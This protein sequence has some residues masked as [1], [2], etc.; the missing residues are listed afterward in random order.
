M[1]PRVAFRPLGSGRSF[2][3]GYTPSPLRG[4]CPC[5]YA[6]GRRVPGPRLS[7]ACSFGSATTMATQAWT[8]ASSVD[9]P[10]AT[11]A[12]GQLDDVSSAS[13]A[14]GSANDRVMVSTGS[15]SVN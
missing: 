3:R 8:M 14:D 7:L 15:S 1:S 13:L 5:A 2:T 9:A 4:V 10:R 11:H 12:S 6:Y